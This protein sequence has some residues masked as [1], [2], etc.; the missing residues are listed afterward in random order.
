MVCG[1]HA[2]GVWTR[3]RTDVAMVSFLPRYSSR[4]IYKHK[5]GQAGLF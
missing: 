1:G 2:L 3:L 5:T 4:K